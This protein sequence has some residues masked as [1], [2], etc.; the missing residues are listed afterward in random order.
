MATNLKQVIK[1]FDVNKNDPR[2]EIVCNTF[3]TDIQTGQDADSQTAI[4]KTEL[5]ISWCSV[6]N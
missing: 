2:N 3:Q 6:Q 1:M 5:R 4:L